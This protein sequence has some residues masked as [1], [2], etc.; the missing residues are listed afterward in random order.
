MCRYG[1]GVN[2][3]DGSQ[4]NDFE[5]VQGIDEQIAALQARKK[6]LLESKRKD[7]LKEIKQA[8][9]IYGF[10][11]NELGL[12]G[13]SKKR[14]PRYANPNDTNQTWSGGARPKWLKEY[15]AGGGKLEDCL[16]K[17]N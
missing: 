8:I 1:D 15:I 12:S 6:E 11:V 17:K 16:V 7:V 2:I 9:Q 4:M 3:G 10:T 5:E 14:Q 13:S